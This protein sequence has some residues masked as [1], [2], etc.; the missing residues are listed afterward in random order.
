MNSAT[1]PPATRELPDIETIQE[2]ESYDMAAPEPIVEGLLECGSKMML[3]GSSKG[4]KTWNLLMLALCVSSPTRTWLNMPVHHC[5]VLYI[6]FE[7]QSYFFRERYRAICKAMNKD[8]M[9]NESLDVWNLR[10]FS[11]NE[12]DLVKAFKVRLQGKHPYKLIIVDPFYKF[13]GSGKVENSAEDIA[14]VMRAMDE[15]T[16]DLNVAVAYAHHAPKGDISERSV[17]DRGSGSGVFGRDPDA[18]MSVLEA[19]GHEDGFIAEFALRNHPPK[20]PIGLRWEFPFMR[21]DEDVEK[22]KAGRKPIHDGQKLLAL[23]A[24]DGKPLSGADWKDLASERLDLPESSYR[25]HRK[26]LVQD[27]EVQCVGDNLYRRTFM[28]A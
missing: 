17:V 8:P 1:P 3:V 16:V 9:A 13:S 22:P 2:I 5:K 21:L 19:K 28:T 4:H 7:I 10:G 6:N 14:S 15:V 23:L 25:R 11:Q 24:P 26:K 12:R 18:I 20:D 27:G